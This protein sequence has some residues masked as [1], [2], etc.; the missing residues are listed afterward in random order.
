MTQNA[1]AFVLVLLLAAVAPAQQIEW[2]QKDFD[3]ALAAAKD[4]ASELLLLYCWQD[5]HDTCSAMFSGTLSDEKV[6]KALAGV[7]CM[8]AK[9]D[10]AGK[11]VLERYRVSRV[12]T[13]LFVQPDGAVVDVVPGYVPVERFVAEVTRIRSGKDTIASLREQCAAAPDDL[14]LKLRL[15]Q[16]LRAS[17]DKAG[18][19]Q[20]IDAMVQQD[21]RL[22]SEE[23]AEAML[24][25]ITD[26][27][28]APGI[29]PANYDL[30]PLRKFLQK[31][32]NKRIRFLGYDR[33]A[34]AEYRRG[35]LKEAADA[36]EQAWKYVPDDQLVDFGQNLAALAYQHYKEL[37]T[38]TLP[39][40]RTTSQRTFAAVEEQ[41]EKQPDAPFL[42][43]A[44][45]VHAAVLIVNK[46]RKQGL[47][48]MEQAM[49][50][51]PKNENLK[52]AYDRW[53]AG[54]K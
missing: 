39:K 31:Q 2:W 20:V 46:Q 26:E 48:L 12:P 23:A 17:G 35:D 36:A 5:Q 29:E 8:G 32:R 47:E 21:E 33:M 37:E 34:A 24:L 25:K 49:Q 53:L 13:V 44:M 4:S 28:F 40:A 6:G 45:Y 30:D 10:A 11:P 50:V 27:T 9:D 51:D 7:V 41:H 18:S 1:P 43:N 22:K 19:L 38:P 42:A 52:K 16:K 54:D 14:A 15:V 3:S